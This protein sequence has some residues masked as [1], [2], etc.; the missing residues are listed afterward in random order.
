[1]KR[2]WLWTAF[3]ALMMFVFLA[4]GG[5]SWEPLQGLRAKPSKSVY[6]GTKLEIFV[7]EVDGNYLLRGRPVGS[8][9]GEYFD[10]GYALGLFWFDPMANKLKDKTVG[11]FW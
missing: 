9:T 1:M 10:L 7:Y 6:D 8:V 3:V 4:I 2:W 11:N 5:I